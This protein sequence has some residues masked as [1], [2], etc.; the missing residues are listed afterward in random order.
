MAF[1]Q[2]VFRNQLTLSLWF[3]IVQV[4]FAELSA[5]IIEEVIMLFETLFAFGSL[6]LCGAVWAQVNDIAKFAHAGKISTAS[7]AVSA[8]LFPFILVM[9]LV[10]LFFAGW[11]LYFGDHYPRFRILEIGLWI[12]LILL[13]AWHGWQTS[14]KEGSG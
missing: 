10:W 2:V 14:S 8:L 9:L 5:T 6:F 3:E 12:V 7:E 11:N 4:G 1:D 13:S